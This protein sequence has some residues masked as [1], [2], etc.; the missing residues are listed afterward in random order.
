[1]SPL[2]RA[3]RTLLAGLSGVAAT[4][5]TIDWVTD[6]RVGAVTVGLALLTVAVASVAAY[7][8]AL[9]D[10]TADSPV[11]KA[12]AQFGQMFGAGLATFAFNSVADIAPM[13][14]SATTLLVTSAFSA[15]AT[16]ALNASEQG[17]A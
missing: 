12:L 1:M 9:G 11:G 7:F 13:A 5:A 17:S 15:L 4:A 14:R 2:A 6:Y 10:H 8:L 16:L 3:V